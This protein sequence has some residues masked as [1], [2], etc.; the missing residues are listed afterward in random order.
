MNSNYCCMKQKNRISQTHLI[1]TGLLLLLMLNVHQLNAQQIHDREQPVNPFVEQQND[2][3]RWLF[4]GIVGFQFGA[5]SLLELSP[6]AG[7]RVTRNFVPGIGLSYQFGNYRNFYLDTETG[8]HEDRNT[9]I[10]GGRLFA[11]YY[12]RDWFQG[13]LSGLF[14][15]AEFEYLTF[16]R[17]F[18]MDSRGKF[19]DR[20]GYPYSKGDETLQIPGFLVGGGLVQPI[21][22]KVYSNILILYN[23]NQTRDTPYSNPVFRIGFGVGF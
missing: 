22:G 15:H 5:Y 13:L 19:V 18:V 20:Y 10:Y 7:Y 17:E 6:V 14:A 8:N 12:F 16:N 21:G 3:R 4:E 23:L 9:N 1:I 11:R 2:E